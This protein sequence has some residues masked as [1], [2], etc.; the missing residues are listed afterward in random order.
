MLQQAAG[1]SSA[2]LR[3]PGAIN[4]PAV[5]ISAKGSDEPVVRNLPKVKPRIPLLGISGT[6]TPLQRASTSGITTAKEGLGHL[7]SGVCGIHLAKK[8]LSGCARRKLKKAKARASKA[9]TGIILQ[10]G[11]AGVPK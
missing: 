4:E 1:S 5:E 10:P 3:G 8:T 11:N 2:P 9:G 6:D 7:V